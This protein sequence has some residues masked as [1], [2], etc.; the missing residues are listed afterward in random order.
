MAYHY[1]ENISEVKV[2]ES[3]KI[4][5]ILESGGRASY[6]HIYR[7]GAGVYWDQD[8]KGFKSTEPKKWSYVEWFSHIIWVTQ[9][10]NIELKLSENTTWLNIPENEKQQIIAKH[11]I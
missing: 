2:L 6:Q 7:E 9:H 3:G 1:S 4:I 10:C 11:A 8:L 5:L